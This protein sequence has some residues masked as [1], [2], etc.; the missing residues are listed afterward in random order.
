LVGFQN[1]PNQNNGKP[2]L[3]L[4]KVRATNVKTQLVECHDIVVSFFPF[5]R[6]KKFSFAMI[7]AIKIDLP[8]FCN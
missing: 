6:L 1:L 3:R 5:M 8:I 7:L 2:K 4:V